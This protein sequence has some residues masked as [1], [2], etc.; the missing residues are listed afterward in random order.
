MQIDGL[1][2]VVYR[3]DTLNLT[4]DFDSDVVF[5]TGSKVI[6][7]VKKHKGDTVALIEKQYD[8][9]PGSKDLFVS[10]SKEEMVLDTGFY[11]YDLVV[12]YGQQRET[13]GAGSIIVKG[14]VHN[15]Q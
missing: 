15:V 12:L 9:N 14:V 2:V 13:L 8:V 6:I 3:G 1:S 7:T 4:F 5:V 11:Y 10:F